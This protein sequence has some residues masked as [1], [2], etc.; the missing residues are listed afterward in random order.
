MCEHISITEAEQRKRGNQHPHICQCYGKQCKHNY[1]KRGAVFIY[2]CKK[3]VADKYKNFSVI[4]KD[5]AEEFRNVSNPKCGLPPITDETIVKIEQAFGFSLYEWQKEY[6]IGKIT[7]RA[8]GRCNGNTFAYCLKLLLI[9]G[10]PLLKK[11]I[12]M[13]IDE[14][15]G[16]NYRKWFANYCFEINDVLKN[17]GIK[18]RLID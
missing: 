3:C 10:E 18:T 1:M 5:D 7:H 2:P 8:G 6:L 12:P 11:N 4:S 16:A 17:A 13:W 14:N 9:D 15:H